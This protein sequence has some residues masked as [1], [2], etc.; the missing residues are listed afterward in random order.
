MNTSENIVTANAPVKN[1]G[2][3]RNTLIP[4]ALSAAVVVLFVMA[5]PLGVLKQSVP[6]IEKVSIQRVILQPEE[7]TVKIVNDGPDPVT[8]SQ[9]LINEAYWKFT[10]EPSQTIPRLGQA[11]I[12]A[13]YSWIEGETEN[14][15]LVTSTGVTFDT[16]VPVATAAPTPNAR[17]LAS[18]AL[19][20]VYVG[21]I[22]V[23]LGLLWL[24]A[25]RKLNLNWYNFLLAL[26]IGLLVFLGIEALAEAI[27]IIQVTP[28][29]YQGLGVLTIGLFLAILLLASVSH[30]GKIKSQLKG[31]GYQNL[32]LAYMVA[33]GIG[34][35]NLGEGLAIGGAYAV[36]EVS[37]GALLVIGF[38]IHNVT[39]GVAVVAPVAKTG[40]KIKQIILM[41]L[42][43]GVPTIFGTWLGGF[44]Y[45]AVWSVFFL[46]VGAGAIFQVVYSI[47][48]YMHKNAGTNLMSFQN[49]AGFIL[50][51]LIMYL[52][53]F[54]VA[55]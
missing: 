15:T 42:L 34:I 18:F 26:T 49:A 1:P 22:P 40:V 54:L 19:L 13:Y 3:W 20:G 52:T 5:G 16:E 50:G 48:N 17:Y 7:M 2:L 28:Q 45:S 4:L 21:V 43:A 11:S 12:H 53:G 37:L 14:I 9:I 27:E 41:G 30:T 25:L 24:P 33:F 6:P 35:H 38:M 10:M 29:V 51:L 8:I 32:I 39:E 31:E 46:S 36:G 23:F 44:T 55:A 47:T